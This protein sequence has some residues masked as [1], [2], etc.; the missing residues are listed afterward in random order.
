MP[1]DEVGYIFIRDPH[2]DPRTVKQNLAGQPGV[3]FVAEFVG[4][5]VVFAAVEFDTL[6]EL[7]EAIAGAYWEAGLRSETSTIVKSSRLAAPKRGSPEYCG[8]VQ[9]TIGDRD[10][11]DVLEDLDQTFEDRF[12]ADPNHEHFWYGAALVTGE[13]DLLIDLGADTKRR[14]N[15]MV[16]RDVR[17]I[18]GILRT[19]TSHAYLPGNEL[20]PGKP[21]S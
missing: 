1:K 9:A 3:Y 17:R 12:N 7:E 18:P 4:A 16:A 8:L 13:F 10:P 5:F 14:I 11:V 2:P 15:E 21:A 19:V 6:Q 20:R